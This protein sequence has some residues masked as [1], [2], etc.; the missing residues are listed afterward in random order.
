[1]TV[2]TPPERSGVIITSGSGA[3]LKPLDE[4]TLQDLNYETPSSEYPPNEVVARHRGISEFAEFTTNL[5]NDLPDSYVRAGLADPGAEAPYWISLTREPDK[6]L[7]AQIESL[8]FR[9]E[10]R[11]GAPA[12]AMEIERLSEE[13]LAHVG[14]HPQLVSSAVATLDSET[15]VLTLEY[16]SPPGADADLTRVELDRAK[17]RAADAFGGELPVPVVLEEMP[18]DLRTEIIV[19]GGR[20]LDLA[21]G[22]PACTAGFTASRNGNR[23][24]L[25]ARHCANN[26]RY[27]GV[28]GIISTTPG[29]PDRDNV[30]AQFHRTLTENGHTTNRQFRAQGTSGDLD[31]TVLDASNAPEGSRVCHWGRTTTYAC[32]DVEDP[33][34]CS[35]TTEGDRFC[36][37]VITD[38]DVSAGGDSGGPWFLGNTARGIHHGATS[39]ASYFTRVSAIRSSLAHILVED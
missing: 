19:Q 38:E 27:N 1:M 11:Y 17:A 7:L 16:H 14:E 29:V 18:T 9:V 3:Q 13:L 26:L 5:E 31:R 23:G 22:L 12:S 30:D 39:G 32:A 35:T 33:Q 36:G 15:N 34:A 6:T 21:S 20:P 2:R 25:T 10:V 37:L 8:P 28:A 24:V 4:E